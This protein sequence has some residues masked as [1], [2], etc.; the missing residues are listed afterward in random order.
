MVLAVGLLLSFA[1]VSSAQ[2]PSPSPSP[3]TTA[4][5]TTTT[6]ATTSTTT[7]AAG[8]GMAKTGADMLLPLAAGGGVLSLVM[9]MRRL[10]ARS[11]S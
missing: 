11:G 1:A 3:S 8:G 2:S 9:G 5:T 6:R 7:S 4:S 10:G